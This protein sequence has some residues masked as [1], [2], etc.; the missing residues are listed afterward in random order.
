MDKTLGEFRVVF[1]RDCQILNMSEDPTLY[2]VRES[3]SHQRLTVFPLTTWVQI[4]PGE[5]VL[6]GREVSIVVFSVNMEYVFKRN[7]SSYLNFQ[8][9]VL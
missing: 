6:P 2:Q 8:G 3:L 4:I 7:A 9:S 1:S 5:Q